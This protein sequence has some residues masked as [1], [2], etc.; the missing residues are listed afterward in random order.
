M[1]IDN[2][3]IITHILSNLTGEY[4]TIVEIIEDYINDKYNPLI[5]ENIRDKLTVKFYQMNEQSGPITSREDETS[6]Y[7]K[8][9]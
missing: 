6:L 7:T 4:Q 5:I 2:S 8:S 1:H 3:E 9:Q